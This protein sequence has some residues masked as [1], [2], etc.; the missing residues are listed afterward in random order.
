MADPGGRRGRAVRRRASLQ[1]LL[2][3]AGRRAQAALGALDLADEVV[4]PDR[5]VMLACR[6]PPVGNRLQRALGLFEPAAQPVGHGQLRPG[7]GFQHPLAP[8]DSGQGLC[9]ER[10]HGFGVTA[11]LGEVST[12][13]CN[14]GWDIR[15][16]ARGG[17]DRRLEGLIGRIRQR[18][19]GGINRRLGRLQAATV[20]RQPR[21]RQAY[22]RPRPGQVR[23]ERGKPPPYR[24]SLV[25]QQEGVGVPLD[26]AGRPGRV[27]GSDR[28]VNG[29]ADE[30]VLFTPGGRSPVQH[31]HPVRPLLLQAGTEQIGEQVMVAPPA[32]HFIQ[33][34]QEQ[35]RPLELLQH[36]LAVGAASDRIAQPAR[37]P[38]QHR[39]FQQEPA[40]L[41]A[42]PLEHLL[43][44]VVQD[45]AMG[46][47]ECRHKL[48]GVGLPAQ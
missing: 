3:G 31:R 18:A 43:G 11:E 36:R 27:P 42:L 20:E 28:V 32:P 35:I 44:Q 7:N 48:G 46:A 25:A 23:R 30:P 34:H 40:H 5:H 22:P 24:Y 26:Q 16:Q 1:R 8:P 47:A 13:Q 19:F 6:P 45:I 37:Q 17:T 4:A 12:A 39:G 38:L 15:Q 10:G 2:V 41:P 29:V 14:R 21:L 9:C 33:R